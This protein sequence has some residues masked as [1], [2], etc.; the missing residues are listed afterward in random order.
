MLAQGIEDPKMSIE[1]A[2]LQARICTLGEPVMAMLGI[3]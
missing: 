3:A 2:A 1:W